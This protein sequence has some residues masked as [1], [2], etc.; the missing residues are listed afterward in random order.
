MYG[1]FEQAIYF[2]YKNNNATAMT[3]VCFLQNDALSNLND[4]EFVKTTVHFQ[5]D[6]VAHDDL[7]YGADGEEDIYAWLKQRGM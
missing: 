5:I 3:C 2:L 6:F 7:P 4:L 1:T